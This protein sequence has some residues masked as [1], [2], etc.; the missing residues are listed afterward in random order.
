MRET[1]KVRISFRSTLG[2]FQ[3]L[4]AVAEKHRW[5]NAK[6]EP[7]LS[8]VL[9]YIIDRFDSKKDGTRRKSDG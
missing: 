5:L 9:N 2:R 3:R 6:G 7:N 8:A 4:R 1:A